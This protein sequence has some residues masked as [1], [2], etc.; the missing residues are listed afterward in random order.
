MPDYADAYQDHVLSAPDVCSGCF[1]LSREER[2]TGDPWA[3]RSQRPNHIEVSAYTRVKE[4]TELD[5]V[6]DRNPTDDIVTWCDCGRQSVYEFDHPRFL[7]GDELLTTARRLLHTLERKRVTV[8]H[9]R[10]IDH[11]RAFTTD[12]T[13]TTCVDAVL[14]DAMETAISAATVSDPEPVPA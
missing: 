5:H 11:V 1:R 7:P 8:D 9:E 10:F 3:D 2:A 13:R 6:P 12:D 14:S 4:T